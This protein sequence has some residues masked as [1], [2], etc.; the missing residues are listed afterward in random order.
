MNTITCCHQLNN[1]APGIYLNRNSVTR[2][3][4]LKDLI[5]TNNYLDSLFLFEVLF[6][7]PNNYLTFANNGPKFRAPVAEPES[8]IGAV[9]SLN[10]QEQRQNGRKC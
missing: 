10:K 8:K 7:H 1:A 5:F 2:E 6:E 3:T 4:Y 9:R